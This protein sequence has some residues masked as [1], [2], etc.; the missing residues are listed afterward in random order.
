MIEPSVPQA[1]VGVFVLGI[2]VGFG[3]GVSYS[4]LQPDN[5][6]NIGEP[7]LEDAHV[8][9]DEDSEVTFVEYSSLTCPFC[10]RHHE[11]TH[12][13]I[14][15]E[16]IEDGEILY[17]YKHFA[18]ND[19]DVLAG[20]AAEC[21]GEQ[22]K[23]FEYVDKAFNNQDNMSQDALVKWAEE[24]DLDMDKWNKCHE[25]RRYTD[26]V[27]SDTN[28]GQSLGVKGTPGFIVN[29]EFISGAQPFSVF[30]NAINSG[31]EE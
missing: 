31:L 9:G 20:N 13:K 25:E 14:K 19:M 23:F 15:E 10:N 24:L 8:Q 1:L 7:D 18:R 26:K 21:A 17:A 6:E 27:I 5:T 28:E 29:G 30:K 2:M 16:Y 11:Q 22:G 4:E 12:P 3:S